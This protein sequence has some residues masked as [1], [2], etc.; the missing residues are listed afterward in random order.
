MRYTLLLLIFIFSSC[1]KI[2]TYSE[3][4]SPM[5]MSNG[6]SS[7]IINPDEPLTVVSFNIEKSQKIDLAIQ[8]ISDNKSTANVDILLLQEMD[9][10]DVM[11]I[12]EALE[13]N[14]LYFPISHSA[15]DDKNFGN[16]ILTKNEILEEDKFILPH[17]KSN[18]RIR[19]ATNCVIEV[20]DKSILLYSIHSETVVMDR[21]KR[22]QQI[23]AIISD[24][25]SKD[26]DVDHVIIGG[27][28]NT[29]L[30]MDLVRYNRKFSAIGMAWDSEDIGATGDYLFGIVKPA[31]DHIYSKNLK[32]LDSGKLEDSKSSDHL[33]IFVKYEL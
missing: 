11:K 25:E 13:L 10:V 26:D 33:P 17:E 32:F 29:L 6:V 1:A 15:G 7:S 16:A 14:Y 12:A 21:R 23:D 3:S 27:D 20:D 18:G 9:Q 19:N 31:N 28:F 5:Y 4:E 22:M 30:K 24:I 2:D 8:E